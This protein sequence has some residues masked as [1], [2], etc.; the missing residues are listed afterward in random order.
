MPEPE[1]VN[2]EDLLVP[3]GPGDLVSAEGMLEPAEHLLQ[4]FP[5]DALQPW[6]GDPSC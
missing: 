1:L 6:D 2:A 5:D 4:P 3:A